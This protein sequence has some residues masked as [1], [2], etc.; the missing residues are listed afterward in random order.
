MRDELEVGL[1]LVL[2]EHVFGRVSQ[3]DD[4]GVGNL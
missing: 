3:W 4:L 2:R 1:M